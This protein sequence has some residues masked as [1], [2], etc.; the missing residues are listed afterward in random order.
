MGWACAAG[1]LHVCWDGAAQML[2][3]KDSY[4]VR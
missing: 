2:A 3:D 1:M 4:H